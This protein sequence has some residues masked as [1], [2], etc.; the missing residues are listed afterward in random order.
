M[1]TPGTMNGLLETIHTKIEDAEIDCARTE[2]K[3]TVQDD[4]YSAGYD[5]GYAEALRELWTQITGDPC[6]INRK[7]Y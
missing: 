5:R 3:M 1:T 6:P 4:N 7:P 2:P